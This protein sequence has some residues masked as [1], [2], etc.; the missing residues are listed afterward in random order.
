[1]ASRVPFT[2]LYD[3]ECGFCCRCAAMLRGLDR[4]HR[5]RLVPLQSASTLV[6]GAPHAAAL[7]E[8]MHVVDGAGRW[9]TGGDAWLR[10]ASVIP[11]LRP[12]AVVGRFPLFHWGVRRLYDLVSRNRHLL[13]CLPGAK[14]CALPRPSR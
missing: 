13:S 4:A 8:T 6:P 3:A 7:L 2:V 9:E 12:L 14:S 10:I 11:G 5:L 1:M